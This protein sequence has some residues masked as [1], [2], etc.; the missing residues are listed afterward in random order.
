MRSFGIPRKPCYR[1]PRKLRHYLEI[2]QHMQFSR[3]YASHKLGSLLRNPDLR[4]RNFVGVD[5]PLFF[6]LSYIFEGKSCISFLRT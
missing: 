1:P 6:C 5:G 3:G 2:Q 4:R